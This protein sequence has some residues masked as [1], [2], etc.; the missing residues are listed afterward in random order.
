MLNS[1]TGSLPLY[2]ADY[3]VNENKH[4]KLKSK[5]MFYLVTLS[6]RMYFFLL[7]VLISIIV[8]N[9]ATVFSKNTYSSFHYSIFFSVTLKLLP[10]RGGAEISSL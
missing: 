1:N 6:E 2:Y 3:L 10:L 7:C 9:I 4:N 5:K 8:V